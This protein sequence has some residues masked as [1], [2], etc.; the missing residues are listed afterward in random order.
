MRQEQLSVLISWA[1]R[2]R[3]L[4][5]W[6]NQDATSYS[7]CWGESASTCPENSRSFV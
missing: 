6:A 5:D 1:I 7:A 2:N 4:A 3:R